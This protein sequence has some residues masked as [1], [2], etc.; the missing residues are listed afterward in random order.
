M[1]RSNNTHSRWHTTFGDFSAN[2]ALGR[3]QEETLK[4]G[5]PPISLSIVPS[6][7]WAFDHSEPNI[8]IEENIYFVPLTANEVGIDSFIVNAEHL[9]MFQFASGIQRSV[10]HGLLAALKRFSNLPPPVNWHYIFVVPEDSA[11]F[12]CPHYVDGFLADHVPYI[13]QVGNCMS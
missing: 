3:A 1:F 2:P 5:P 11:T 12:S 7:S 8:E 6:G 10:N 13:A 9:Y 4:A